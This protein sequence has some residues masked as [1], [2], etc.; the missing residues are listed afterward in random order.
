MQASNIGWGAPASAR[1]VQHACHEPL[2]L[3]FDF[4]KIIWSASLGYWFFGEYVSVY[5]LAGGA[6]IFG[7]A[8]YVAIREHQLEKALQDQMPKTIDVAN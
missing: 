7:G 5:T 8:C 4:A 1:P 3:P 6:I 2:V